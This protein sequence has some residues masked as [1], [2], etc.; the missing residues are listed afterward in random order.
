M[1]VAT[2]FASTHHFLITMASTIVEHNL[3]G[4]LPLNRET[5]RPDSLLLSQTVKQPSPSPEIQWDP[6]P[7][8]Y[9]E[10]VERLAKV[11]EPLAQTV[12]DGFPT[13]IQAPRVWRG[14]EFD[15]EAKYTYVLT[16][17]DLDEIDAAVRAFLSTFLSDRSRIM[18]V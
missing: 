9:R 5:V 10:R 1:Q 2:S 14:S 7:V 12:P 15:D 3:T 18:I 11:L 8:T 4:S 6:S 16:G 13:A 17:D